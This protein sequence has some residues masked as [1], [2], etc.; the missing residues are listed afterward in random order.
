MR[1]NQY[2]GV[3]VEYVWECS[4]CCSVNSIGYRPRAGLP[5]PS[6]ENCEHVDKCDEVQKEEKRVRAGR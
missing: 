5:L 3:T 2:V 1:P 6:C 4:A